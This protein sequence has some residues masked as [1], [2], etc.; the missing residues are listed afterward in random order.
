VEVGAKPPWAV[1]HDP[2]G[3]NV[4]CIEAAGGSRAGPVAPADGRRD[5]G[6]AEFL[7]SQRGRRS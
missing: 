2:E 6:L 1:L 7:V 4:V 3:H 5:V